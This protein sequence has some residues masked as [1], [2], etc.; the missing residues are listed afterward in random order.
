MQYIYAK[1]EEKTR[2]RYAMPIYNKLV[3]DRI[4]EIIE[5]EGKTSTTR[6]LSEDEYFTEVQKKMHEELVEYEEA[7]ETADK[8]EEL[9]DLLELVHTAATLHGFSSNE[10]E[11]LREKKA[12]RRG[13]F[14]KRIYL[15][16]VQDY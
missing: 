15:I 6:L 16:N 9:A 1:L 2:K 7:A 11:A 12:E 10:L 4:P 3:R 14:A 5:K 13:G 8:L